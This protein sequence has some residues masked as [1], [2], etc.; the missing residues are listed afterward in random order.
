MKDVAGF[1][2]G[3]LGGIAV[4]LLGLEKLTE[5]IKLLLGDRFRE[6]LQ[7]VTSNR[8]VAYLAGIL[9]AALCQSSGVITVLIVSLVSAKMLT[10]ARAV[11][12]ILGANVGATVVGQLLS[13]RITSINGALI[14]GGMILTTLPQGWDRRAWLRTGRL[15]GSGLI[16]LGL[17]LLG[18]QLMSDASVVLRDDPSVQAAL[19]AIPNRYVAVLLGIAIT[20]VLQSSSALSAIVISMAAQ[21]LLGLELGAAFIL[22]SNVGSCVPAVLASLR[23]TTAARQ[24]AAVHVAFNC[25]LVLV[26]TPLLQVLCDWASAFS[27]DVPQQLA[28]TL[29]ISNAVV[30]TALVPVSSWFAAAIEQMFG[31][32]CP[33]SDSHTEVYDLEVGTAAVKPRLKEFAAR[34]V[35]SAYIGTL[36]LDVGFQLLDRDTGELNATF[37]HGL[38]IFSSTLC[39][40]VR[41]PDVTALRQQ[42]VLQLRVWLQQLEDS[43]AT[44]QAFHNGLLRASSLHATEQQSQQL[45]AWGAHLQQ[46]RDTIVALRTWIVHTEEWFRQADE[47]RHPSHLMNDHE[48]AHILQQATEVAASWKQQQQQVPGTNN[49][50]QTPPHPMTVA[51]DAA[52]NALRHY[53]R[54]LSS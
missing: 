31:L 7:R 27:D 34:H 45:A 29:T 35:A 37:A 38:P 1:V 13:F 43:L 49:S 32:V 22:G 8:A 24:A 40:H 21:G 30:A 10:L 2:M 23:Q 47:Q 48:A 26:W 12:V 42:Q 46:W 17:V 52:M 11:P 28:N 16:G 5:G 51:S 14:A 50:N 3:I 19:L 39:D 33:A 41:S 36:S 15:S 44:L 9:V 18:M 6:V 20:C 53:A 25:L 54:P 4:F